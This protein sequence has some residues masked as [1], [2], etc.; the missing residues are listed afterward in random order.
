MRL[1]LDKKTG[2][3][4]WCTYEHQFTENTFMPEERF[5]EN[6][7]WMA[8]EFVP[9]GYEMVCTVDRGLFLHQ[10]KWIPDPPS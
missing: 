3:L 10:R 2:P 4:Y 5:K 1:K 7:D 8:K 9:Y 6:I